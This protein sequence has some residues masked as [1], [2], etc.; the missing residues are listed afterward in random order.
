MKESVPTGRYVHKCI[1]SCA[2]ILDNFHVSHMF[3]L[4]AF[5]TAVA[6]EVSFCSCYEY[7]LIYWFKTFKTEY[8]YLCGK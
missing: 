8:N 2:Y 6:S 1:L 4:I 5:F 3:L 7:V